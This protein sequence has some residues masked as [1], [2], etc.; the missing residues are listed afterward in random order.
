MDKQHRR[1]TRRPRSRR[2]GRVVAA[3]VVLIV[4]S[5]TIGVLVRQVRP[6]TEASSGDEGLPRATALSTATPTP[7]PTPTADPDATFTVVAAG[8]VLP[9]LNVLTSARTADGYDFSPLLAGLD[10]WVAGA[11]LALCHFEV[12]VA[13][14][15]TKPSG[16]P[17]FGTVDALVADQAEQGWDGCSTASNHSVDRGQAGVEATISSFDTYGLGHVGTAATQ[18]QDTPQLYRLTRAGRTFTVAHLS[19]TYGTNGMPVPQPWTVDLMDADEVVAQATAARAAGADLVLVSVHA[20]TEYRTEP[21][22][23]QIDFDQRLAD[24]GQ[25]DLVI[26]HHA[27]VPQPIVQLAGGP[28]GAGMWVAYGLGNAISNQ[29]EE[30][31]GAATSSGELLVVQITATGAFPAQDVAAG[32]ATVTGVSYAP[33]TVDRRSGHR[34]HLLTDIAGGTA[35]LSATQVAERLARVEEAAGTAAPVATTAPTATGDLPVVVPRA[36]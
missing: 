22:Q 26:G 5:A 3:S 9:H 14:A 31:C 10:T 19:V 30:C 21:T 25:V 28:R 23:D 18:A 8:D 35:T 1:R 36:G 7:T 32:P 34:M 20:G 11:D 4:L 2:S 29:D 15:G 6:Q 17:L 12:P 33:I 27:H 24:S 16:Y 13:P